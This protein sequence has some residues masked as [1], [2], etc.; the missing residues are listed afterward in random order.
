MRVIEV[1]AKDHYEAG[2]LLGKLTR[3]LQAKFFKAFRP[4]ESWEELIRKSQPYLSA[5]KKVFPQYIDEIRGLSNG[6]GI[7]FENLWVFHCLDEIMKKEFVEKCSSVFA[8]QEQDHA[9][10]IGHNEDWESWTKD[11][12]FILKRSLDNKTVLELG[13]AGVICAGTVSVNSKGLVQAINS[14]HH[15]DYQ[16]G[17]PKQIVARWL[18]SRESLDRVMEEFPKLHRAAGYCY[19]L[20]QETQVLSIESS[21]KEFEFYESKKSYTHTNHYIGILKEVE[22]EYVKKMPSFDR[23]RQIKSMLSGINS[24]NR[25]KELLMF[26][27]P[28]NSSV[29]RRG[30]VATVASVIFDLSAKMCYLTQENRGA[31]TTWQNI[32][33]DFLE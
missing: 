16:I 33:L 11:Y 19:N 5:T 22:E 20:S 23:Y 12:Y 25:L 14:L 4:P 8:K 18:S 2:F 3:K 27:S 6:S 7:P 15:T 31:E 21:A 32:E 1:E 30:E 9:Y 28:D 29:Y 17:T 26:Q 10:L 13:M 24:L